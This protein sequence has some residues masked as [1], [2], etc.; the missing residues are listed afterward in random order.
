MGNG[1]TT[2]LIDLDD[3]AT[4]PVNRRVADRLDRYMTAAFGNTSS[5]DRD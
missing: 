1:A 3:R 5:I 2:D 4:T